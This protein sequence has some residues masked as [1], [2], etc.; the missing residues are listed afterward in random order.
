MKHLS[1][2]LFLFALLV[3]P[4]AA[5][6]AADATKPNV[7][8]LMAD[9]LG[10]YEPGFMGGKTIQTPNLDKMAAGGIMPRLKLGGTVKKRRETRAD[11]RKRRKRNR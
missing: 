8:Y 10:Y 7:I 1:M 4:L 5:L 6:Q 3:V 11:K 2:T 9:E